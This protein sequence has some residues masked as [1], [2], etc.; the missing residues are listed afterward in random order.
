[1]S[2][3]PDNRLDFNLLMLVTVADTFHRQAATTTDFRFFGYV[4]DFFGSTG[5]LGST[6]SLERS[7]EACFSVDLPKRS[8]LSCRISAISY[9]G[10]KA[11]HFR[12]K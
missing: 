3:V 12:Q 10:T 7:D 8:A 1:M 11:L 9:L 2:S 5:A 4:K 6:N